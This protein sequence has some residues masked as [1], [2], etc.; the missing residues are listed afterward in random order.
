MRKIF[1]AAIAALL[2]AIAF[3]G[4]ANA[5]TVIATGCTSVTASNGCLFSGNINS[6]N[7]GPNSYLA[8]QAAY[9]LFN[10]THPSAN[11]DISLKVIAASDDSGFSGFGSITGG[12]GAS[13]TWSLT[14]YLVDFIAVKASESFVL[15]QITPASS[16]NWNTFDIPYHQ[17]PHDLSH[18]VFF[19]DPVSGV[20]EPA[21]WAL[22]ILGFGGIGL[23]LRSRRSA[24]LARVR[25]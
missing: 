25:A 9:N 10:N 21:T 18:I 16:G 8:T 7:S 22:F 6:S 11:P 20:P 24:I 13:G 23:M 3:T 2:G 15:Y 19:G 14:N 4:S 5:A 17:N 12:S 1:G